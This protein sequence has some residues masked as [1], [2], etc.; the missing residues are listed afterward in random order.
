MLAEIIIALLLISNLYIFIRIG[1]PARHEIL[2]SLGILHRNKGNEKQTIQHDDNKQ[3]KQENKM[4]KVDHSKECKKNKV[5]CDGGL[6]CYFQTSKPKKPVC[7]ECECLECL[8]GKCKP[9]LKGV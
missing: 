4:N 9:A 8:H 7:R 5:F 2:W 6:G 1:K 3:P